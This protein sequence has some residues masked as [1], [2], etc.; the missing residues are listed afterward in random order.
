[1]NPQHPRKITETEPVF[2][3]WLWNTTTGR[4]NRWDGFPTKTAFPYYEFTHWHLD[5]PEAPTCVPEKSYSP[6]DDPPEYH[7]SCAGG[8]S[9]TPPA[10]GEAGTP[11]TDEAAIYPS[12]FPVGGGQLV[13]ADF[14]RTLE[15]ESAERL[16]VIQSMYR[17]LPFEH[18]I[19]DEVKSVDSCVAQLTA[20]AEAL[21]V[22][23]EK[24][25]YVHKMGLRFGMMKTSD[26]PEP[27]LAHTWAEDSDY[28]RMFR[29]WSD[30]IGWQD[31]VAKLTAR[32]EAAEAKLAEVTKG[33]DELKA[34]K[35][36]ALAVEREWD[37]QAVGKLLDIPLGSS[38]R[39]GIEPAIRALQS[40][41]ALA[42]EEIM[43][44]K[45]ALEM[46]NQRW[47]AAMGWIHVDAVP[48]LERLRYHASKGGPS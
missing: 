18:R 28:E 13:P 11:R 1:M 35:E 3:C 43:R 27:Y 32:A 4:W 20:Q 23:N 12:Q 48:V 44:L 46:R 42:D 30:S 33:R 7:E 45:S 34:W 29:E 5:Q 26:K 19:G 14:A 31:A 2:P 38:V 24:L 6:F 37:S 16:N 22:A 17:A 15:R 21:Q 9:S 25:D 39:A 40:C 10:V 36:S 8:P 47:D 41:L